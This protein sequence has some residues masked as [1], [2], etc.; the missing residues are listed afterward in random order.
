MLSRSL[1][2]P[3][4]VESLGSLGLVTVSLAWMLACWLPLLIPTAGLWTLK[5]EY[6]VDEIDPKIASH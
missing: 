5:T 6:N 4:S 2:S 1:K 3:M